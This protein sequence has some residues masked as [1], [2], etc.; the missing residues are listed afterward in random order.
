MDSIKTEQRFD[1]MI[2]NH[3]K[4]EAS[5]YSRSIYIYKYKYK[6]IYIYL[7]IYI[8]IFEYIYI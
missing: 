4:M 3:K 1:L 7:N 2:A 6:Y 8:Y 5:K